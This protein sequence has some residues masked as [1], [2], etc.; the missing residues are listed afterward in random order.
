LIAGEPGRILIV[1]GCD[2]RR[3]SVAAAPLLQSRFADF[4]DVRAAVAPELLPAWR[5]PP[6]LESQG[7]PAR[8][9]ATRGGAVLIMPKVSIE[10]MTKHLAASDVI[11]SIGT[12]EWAKV[13]IYGDWHHTATRIRA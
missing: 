13:R 9:R 10:A 1:P 2:R 11:D 3:T 4:R 6:G 8:I 12:R 7:T 5:L